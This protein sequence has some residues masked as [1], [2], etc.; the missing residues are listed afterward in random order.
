MPLADNVDI[1]TLHTLGTRS[2]GAATKQV[3]FRSKTEELFTFGR[4][5]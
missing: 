2:H 5:G 4:Y 1:V 3:D